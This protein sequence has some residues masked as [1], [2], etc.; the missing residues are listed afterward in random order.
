MKE[1]HSNEGLRKLLA[2]NV[3]ISDIG[4]QGLNLLPFKEEILKSNVHDCLF[5]GCVLDGE[6]LEKIC[7]RN[8]VFPSFKMPFTT[9]PNRLYHRGDLYQG[10]DARNP[11]SY[12]ESPDHKI[13]QHFTKFGKE[14]ANLRVS[15]ARRLHDHGISDALHEFLHDVPEKKIVGIMGGHSML[16]TDPMYRQI[17]HLSSH[18]SEKGYM[19]VSGGGPG[20]MEAT[21][22]GVWLTGQPR[23]VW[24]KSFKILAKAPSYKDTLWLSTAFEVIERFP[25]KSNIKSLGIPTWLY[26]HEPPTPFA[27]HIAKYFANSLREDGLLAIAKGGVVFSPGSAGTIQE[28]FQDATQNHYLTEEISSPM[29]FLGKKYWTKDYPIFSLLKKMVE[30]DKYN[31]LILSLTDDNDEVIHELENFSFSPGI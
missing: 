6:M 29:V 22:L 1:I 30:E 20:A 7:L 28:I 12:K 9:H 16:R 25:S 2:E 17:T 15:L 11:K 19:M 24:D 4:F 5:L 3:E 23:D 21:H 31:N 27:S 14:P 26:G 8:F 18:L 13:Y 10:F